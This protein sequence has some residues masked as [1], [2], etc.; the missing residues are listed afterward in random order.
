MSEQGKTIASCTNDA[1]LNELVQLENYKTVAYILGEES[2]ADETFST[3]EQEKV[4][5]YLKQGG[6]LLATGAE[7]A[8]DLDNKGSAG[9]KIFATIS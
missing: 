7:I 8:W 4:K 5:S 2:T 9:I 1:V 3:A 6:N